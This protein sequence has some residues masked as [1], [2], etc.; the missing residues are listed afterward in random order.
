[1]TESR[2][3]Q[4][5][6]TEKDLPALNLIYELAIE[7]YES[8]RQRMITQDERIRHIV[9]LALTITATVPAVYQIFKISPNLIFLGIA[10]LLFLSCLTLC[11]IATAKNEIIVMLINTLFEHYLNLSEAHTKPKFDKKTVQKRA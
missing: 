11:T 5:E 9:T 10:G 7:S 3:Q 6:V 1:M 8:A 2:Q 4:P